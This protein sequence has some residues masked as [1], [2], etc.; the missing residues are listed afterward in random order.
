MRE[1]H[2]LINPS[3]GKG[4]GKNVI[5]IIKEIMNKAGI[6]Y[7]IKVSK[8]KG[9]LTQLTVASVT[10]GATDIIAV[11]GDGTL[12]EV[13]AGMYCSDV[14]LG[15]IPVGTGNDFSKYFGLPNDFKS[16]IMV[17]INGNVQSIDIGLVNKIPFINVMSC[18]IDSEIINLV[19]SYKK[20]LPGS[21]AYFLCSIR[22]ITKYKPIC[23]E[24]EID[25]KLKEIEL[26]LI[27]IGNGTHFGG[28]M[29][30]TPEAKLDDGYLDICIIRKM[31]V[32]KL[33][34]C[35]PM[36]IKGNHIQIEE[37]TYYKTKAL[38]ATFNKCNIMANIDGDLLVNGPIEV[39][40][41]EKKVKFIV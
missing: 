27:A 15:L 29:A 39:S 28:G 25:G 10:E 12:R 41:L 11:G 5:P 1:I 34:K 14:Q 18:G 21:I 35:F 22:A 16:A 9:M 8:C 33:L 7:K 24:I 26:I 38:K 37:V 30:I 13:M 2:Y 20:W 32:W 19:S 23:M 4:K 40:I 6:T 17:I 31:P 3:S 36:L